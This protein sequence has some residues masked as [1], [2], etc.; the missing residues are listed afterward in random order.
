MA[1]ALKT[2]AIIVGA[3]ALIAT[4]VGA[5][6][7]A[8]LIGAGLG[9]SATVLGVSAA[10]LTAVGA[11]AGAVS[12][13]LSFGAQA[14]TKPPQVSVSGDQTKFTFSKDQGIP[15]ALGRTQVS[16]WGIHR[17][18]YDYAGST[19]NAYQ[20]VFGVWSGGGPIHL[21]ESFKYDGTAVTF[22]GGDAGA[23][24]G[25][26]AGYMWLNR[27][28][29]ATP[30]ASALT[31][32][33]GVP[34]PG[35]WSPASKLSGY[36]AFAWTAKWDKEGKKFPA[37]LQEPTAIVE[38]ALVYD[39]RQ[40]STQPG[41]SG[42]C[43]PL[44]ESTYVWAGID[45][46]RAAAKNGALQALTW[47][48]GRWQNAKRVLGI[49][50]T[51]AALD[52]PAFVEAANVADANGWTSGGVVY[53]TDGK[54][55]VLKKMLATCSAEP[56]QLGGMLSCRVD[57]PRVSL[58][59][60]TDAD[61]IGACSVVATPTIS[62]RING[63]IPSC[64][65]EGQDWSIV[66]CDRVQIA[67]YV[68]A[69]G[70]P[71]TKAV[72]WELVQDAAQVAQLAAY[73]ICAARE[74]GP[75]I[76]PLKLRWVGYKP[77]DCLTV[78]SA[79]L[80]M[81]SQPIIVSKRHLDP[82]TGA[83]T[84]TSRSETTA[85]HDYALGRT[86]LPPPTP[87]LQVI[88]KATLLIPGVDASWPAIA[89]P[90]G[91]KP[92]D[93]AT[94]GAPGEAP[95]GDRTARALVDSVDVNTQSI[96]EE[97]LRQD[98]LLQVFDARTLVEGQPV[99]TTFLSFRDAQ[100]TK[101]TATNT[102]FSLLGA[103]TADGTAW[104]LNLDTVKVSPEKTLATRLGEIGAVTDQAT[105][106]VKFLQDIFVGDG[107]A[108]AKAVL[109]ADANGVFGA[110]DVSANGITRKSTITM[111][112]NELRFVDPGNGV[113]VNPFSISGGSVYAQNFV[114]DT[115]TYASLV[116]RF[117][118]VGRQNLDPSGWY[119]EL[120]G[121]LIMQGGRYRGTINQETTKAISFPRP[122]PNQVLAVGATPFLTTFSN[123][124]DLWM[125]NVGEPSLTGTIFGTQSSTNNAQYIDGFDWWAWGR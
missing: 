111:V 36:A 28:L 92:E 88:D 104:N 66:P 60:I 11:V 56:L 87:S 94:Y 71:R 31:A 79:N 85:K 55:D 70:K 29:G 53:S 61:I 116:Q 4:G 105:V 86:G 101:N 32:N 2:A 80:G 59:T 37:G 54:L 69:D 13:V 81:D 5:A 122:F 113:A 10:T 3:V 40:D 22:A 84:L 7:S 57:T 117:S 14:L 99:G 63:I 114:A 62:E 93:N 107:Q 120:P 112:A 102:A 98:D 118:D 76:T 68:T 83:V 16:G 20:T 64:R 49:G 58:A 109:R 9:A 95:V 34:Y 6:A 106:S 78:Q 24:T 90:D 82:D 115:I 74:F 21:V 44:D 100:V 43:R 33:A 12:A 8:G 96:L 48:L 19:A 17:Q 65:L 41:G 72:T 97:A 52:I 45:A 67:D 27:Q 50:M 18:T 121:G 75:I 124:R 73:T 25:T 47:A 51:L 108:S 103:K 38:G 123:V 91:T 26:Y 125:Q 46:D 39:P 35:G 30:A 110:F 42:P 23:A 15:H 89:D 77:G 1:K 119:Q